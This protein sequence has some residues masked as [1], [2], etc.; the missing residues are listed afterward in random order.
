MT[1]HDLT[2]AGYGLIALGGVVLQLLSHRE[3][4]SIPSFGALLRW[5]MARR[6][7][8]IGIL[9][10]WAWLGLHFFVR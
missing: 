9:A 1:S 8:R 4:S 3:G 5:A 10:G 7:A 2:L 6:S